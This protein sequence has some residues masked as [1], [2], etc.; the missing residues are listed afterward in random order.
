MIRHNRRSGVT[1]MEVL[2]AIMIMGVGMLAILALFPLGALSMARA[3]RDDRGTTQ[4]VNADSM[5]H[6]YW[7]QAWND[8]TTG[9]VWPTNYEAYGHSQE[10]MLFLLENHAGFGTIPSTADQ[11][12]YPV[13]VD[14]IGWQTNI[15]TNSQSYVAGNGLLPMRTTLRRCIA[16][17]NG[18]PIPWNVGQPIPQPDPIINNPPPTPT[19][20]PSIVPP[21]IILRLTTLLDEFSYDQAGEPAAS[22][23]QLERGGRYTASW[24]IQRKR[25]NVP[26][27]VDVQVLVFAGRA[28]TDTPSSETAFA[29]C[30]T[31]AGTKQIVVPLNGQTPPP[32]RRGGW[33]ALSTPVPVLQNGQPT[34]YPC[35][36]F[37]RV[38]AIN[39]DI[40]DTLVIETEAPI[41]AYSSMGAFYQGF[42][43]VFDNLI[44]VFDRGTVAPSSVAV[45]GR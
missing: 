9:A 20:Y 15:G 34:L 10:P 17:N 31:T 23:G 28:P 27:E 26:H 6:F 45:P 40:P 19:Q 18:Y 37:Y 39:D 41:K 1:L 13:L 16:I 36:D 4:G 2:I 33:I 24:L 29:N 38:V 30:S 3:I 14:P 42:V 7:K 44:E 43:I 32:L 8:P 21:G 22:T 11:P 5:F 35:M 25:N 12:S